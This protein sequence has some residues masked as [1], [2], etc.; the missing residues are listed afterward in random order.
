MADTFHSEL[1]PSRRHRWGACPGSVREEAKY[2]EPPAGDAAN[3]GTR[4]HAMLEEL[5]KAGCIRF[6]QSFVGT[7]RTDEFG[8]FTIDQG[9]A[10]RLNLAIDYIRE[11]AT[12][13]GEKPI[14]EQRV[15]P[16]GLV[17]RGDMSGTVDCQIPGKEVY[18]IID[19]KDGM[20]PVT[21][22]NNPQLEMYAL[23]VLAG[24][25][26]KPKSFQ[27]TIIQPKLAMKGM[28]VISSWNIS[29]KALLER[30]PAIIAEASA[31]DASDAPL[32]PGDSQC[33]YCRAKGACPA[34]AGKVNEVITM[35]APVTPTAVTPTADGLSLPEIIARKDPGVLSSEEL[36]Q[37]LNAIPLVEQFIKGVEAESQRRLE[38]GQPVPGYKLVRGKG[39]RGWALP[40]EEMEK[41]LKGMGVPGSSIYT[42]KIIS[43]AQAESL[44]W[45]KGE[46]TVKLSPR[47]IEKMQ[48]EYVA[49]QPGK[50]TL[51]P[52]SDPREAIVMDAAPMFAAINTTATPVVDVVEGQPGVFTVPAGTITEPLPSFLAPVAE[53]PPAS[54]VPAW[55]QP[56][57]WL[58]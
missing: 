5:I 37:I 1:S 2:P 27:F 19:Y 17:G 40:E 8:T 9:R 13:A 52:E 38:S 42:K 4:T 45:Q 58:Q 47:Q 10:D 57:A 29:T 48:K 41:K 26:K 23:G 50:P 7:Q 25:E 6:P 16:D 33:K 20:A 22:E 39:S 49:Q 43:P 55:L 3:D 53:I 44:T 21:A 28:P 31:C 14:A 34:L 18:E 12:A 32:I 56:P 15:Y 54:E 24:L 51:A 35:F 36:A 46:E 30:V 11:R